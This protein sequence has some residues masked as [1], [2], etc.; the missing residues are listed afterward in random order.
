MDADAGRIA[1][2]HGG[3]GAEAEEVFEETSEFGEVHAA[4]LPCARGMVIHSMLS[5]LPLQQR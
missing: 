1:C 2:L 3:D 5:F 4:R